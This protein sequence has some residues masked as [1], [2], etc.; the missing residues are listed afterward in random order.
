MFWGGI[1]HSPKRISERGYLYNM[2]G[3]LI[4]LFLLV[5]EKSAQRW[6]LN[7]FGCTP[8]L[9]VRYKE[10][11]ENIKPKPKPSDVIMEKPEEEDEGELDD[12][13][14]KELKKPST[15]KLAVLDEVPEEEERPSTIHEGI[16]RTS[17]LRKTKS[18]RINFSD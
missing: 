10:I 18:E 15:K 11:E 7:R 2:Y 9:I 8:D 3:Y 4:I 16:K 17:T 13:V 6:A 5:L 12:K 14:E 1:Y